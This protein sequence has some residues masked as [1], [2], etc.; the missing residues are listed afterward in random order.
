MVLIGAWLSR[1]ERKLRNEQ[2][3][4]WT[5][6]SS[7]IFYSYPGPPIL[8][9]KGDVLNVLV[10]NKLVCANG[11]YSNLNAY[12]SVDRWKHASIDFHGTLVIWLV[13]PYMFWGIYSRTLMVSS[14]T[15]RTGGTRDPTSSLRVQWVP[16]CPSPIT[17]RLLPTKLAPS[18]IIGKLMSSAT[19]QMAWTVLQPAFG[20]IRG[21][22]SRT[23]DCLWSVINNHNSWP[24]LNR[25]QTPMIRSWI[26]TTS[27][28]RL[29]YIALGFYIKLYSDCGLRI[30]YSTRWL[31]AN[32]HSRFAR[33]LREHRY[34]SVS[35]AAY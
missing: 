9:Q 32:C 3:Y 33:K 21:W 11:F 25:W 10:N 2:I 7:C 31:V 20:S 5:L 27:M 13:L 15:R 26:S 30:D 28:T 12:D 34:C 6:F 24:S 18:G 1:M 19:L 23:V 8:V 17:Y 35:K 29:R 16:T 14:S 4:L 22:S